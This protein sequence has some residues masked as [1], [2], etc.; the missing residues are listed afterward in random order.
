MK[1]ILFTL[2]S[3]ANLWACSLF[4]IKSADDSILV[5]RN[6][7][8]S[9]SDG[10][11]AFYPA[12][13]RTHGMMLISQD[14]TEM[15]YEGMNDQGLFVGISAVP[16]SPTFYNVLM[17]TRKSLSMVKEVLSRASTIDEAIDVFEMFNINFGQFLG[18]PLIHFK[19]VHQSGEKVVIEFVDDKMVVV[20]EPQACTVM[21]N[22]YNSTLAIEPD[23]KTS[24][25]RYATLNDGLAMA[26][27]KEHIYEALSSVEQPDT[28]WSNVYDLTLQVAYLKLKGQ[29][30]VLVNLKD[31]LYT[32][33]TPH[34]FTFSKL[35][36][37]EPQPIESS[38]GGVLIRPHFG[39]GT[40]GLS[41]VGGRLLL[42]VNRYQKYG[43]EVT[44]FSNSSQ[45][46]NAVGIMLEQ[47][48]WNWFNM[49]MGTVGYL[50][51]G[52]DKE[53]TFG[54]STNLGWEPDNNIPFLPFVTFR[55]DFI[56]AQQGF[57]AL[58]SVSIGFAF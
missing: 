35:A 41:H 27:T 5:G 55:S 43:L 25:E 48:L 18:N 3:I 54:F 10:K 50:G 11:V 36:D 6:F 7:D 33:Q 56:F 9:G 40:E 29:E 52:D 23:S 47:R 24:K 22:H 46:F 15:P 14:N 51:Y 16:Y 37:K 45:N 28:L 42:A 8:W 26:T 2:L 17:P 39:Y 31:E 53:N 34:Y 49:S 20:R 38:S 21:T 32:I 13:S 12:T 58:S 57:N 19:I 4:D 1:R 30:R 44:N